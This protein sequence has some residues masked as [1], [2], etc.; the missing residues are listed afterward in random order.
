MN[1]A[2]HGDVKNKVWLKQTYLSTVLFTVMAFFVPKSFVPGKF[3]PGGV[4][5]F[6]QALH[7]DEPAN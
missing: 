1:S 6:L 4:C 7:T 2:V 3:V 5:D